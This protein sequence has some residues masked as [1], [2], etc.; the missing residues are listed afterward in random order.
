MLL[1]YEFYFCFV[2]RRFYY[3][4]SFSFQTIFHEVFSIHQTF[5]T[6]DGQLFNDSF[7]GGCAKFALFHGMALIMIATAKIYY[8]ETK[9]NLQRYQIIK[10]TVLQW[11]RVALRFR[12]AALW[13]YFQNIRLQRKFNL[14]NWILSQRQKNQPNAKLSPENYSHFW[15]VTYYHHW[16]HKPTKKS[17]K[18]KTF[19]IINSMKVIKL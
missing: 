17:Q 5:E 8:N 14:L 12:N 19:I 9:G 7:L 3:I 13:V 16:Q 18:V 10:F 11:H 4:K 2:R 15:L 1:T 6:F